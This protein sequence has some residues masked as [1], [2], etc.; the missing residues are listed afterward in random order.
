MTQLENTVE[1]EP[2]FTRDFNLLMVAH[3]MQA[4]GFSSMLLL[5]LYLDFLD[6]SRAEIGSVMAA[7]AIGGL[8]ARPGIAWALDRW[9]RR[10]T[11]ATGTIILSCSMTLILLIEEV[12]TTAYVMR[13]CFG[14][15]AGACFSGYFTFAA[16]LIPAS[17]RTE[18]LAL[19]GVTGLVPLLVN[20]LSGMLVTNPSELRWFLPCVGGAVV[21]SLLP[22][23]NVREKR[24]QMT[25]PPWRVREVLSSLRST[26]LI[27]VWFVTFVF[28]GLVAIF[29]SFTTVTAQDRG[30]SSPTHIW[31]MYALGAAVIRISGAKMLDRIGPSNLVAPALACYVGSVL[32][33]ATAQQYPD[34]LLAGSLAGLGH[35]ICFPILTSQVVSRTPEH[36]RGSAM[37]MF[38]AIWSLSGLLMPPLF[39]SI[40]DRYDDSLMFLL[41]AM[42]ATLSLVG[43]VT[44]EHRLAKPGQER[45]QETQ[46]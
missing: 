42:W 26:P 13:V 37:A 39:G 6:A 40:S 8:C 2:L 15:G 24:N 18:G 34:I 7:A 38:T 21:C 4:L 41:A 1:V 23:L 25:S 3:F 27:P 45:V 35:G 28:S 44:L 20:P 46:S 30:I 16:D 11:L 14:I 32:A 19:F 29:F 33:A 10:K 9:G 36:H 12:G 22:L 17:R 5:P 31:Y 43:W